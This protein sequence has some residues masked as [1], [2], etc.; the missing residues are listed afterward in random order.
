M[1]KV[2]YDRFVALEHIEKEV[3][4]IAHTK[5]EREELWQI[6]DEY[7]HQ[8]MIGKILHKLPKD[9]HEE[10]LNKFIDEPHSD[11]HFGYLTEKVKE[12]VE[13]FMKE[14]VYSI[15]VDLLSVIRGK[16]IKDLKASSK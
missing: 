12:D 8:R 11:E 9:H 14:E 7:I 10:F 15:G 2:F 5:E 3:N 16:N 4:K 6:I 1:S 13:A